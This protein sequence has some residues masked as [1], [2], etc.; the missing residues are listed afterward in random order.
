MFPTDGFYRVSCHLFTAGLTIK[1]GKVA[2]EKEGTAPVF[3]SYVGKTAAE[4]EKGIEYLKSDLEEPVTVT[5]L[6]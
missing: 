2:P 1:N 4:L 6:D 5:R 3:F